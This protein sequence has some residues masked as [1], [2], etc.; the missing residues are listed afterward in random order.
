MQDV[1]L[2]L[3]R[4]EAFDLEGLLLSTRGELV[5]IL[6]EPLINVLD[7]LAKQLDDLEEG[8]Q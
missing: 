6:T 2:Q 1:I 8:E 3:S 7:K 4:Q 5:P